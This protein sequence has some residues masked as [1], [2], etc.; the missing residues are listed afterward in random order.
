MRTTAMQ[1]KVLIGG[2]FAEA[3]SGETMEVIAPA[4]GET[5]AEVPLPIYSREEYTQLKHVAFKID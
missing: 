2:D 1:H 3:A 5:I 4:I